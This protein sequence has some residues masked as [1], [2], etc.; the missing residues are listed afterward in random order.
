MSSIMRVNI[1]PPRSLLPAP[2]LACVKSYFLPA[3]SH[4]DQKAQPKR[5]TDGRK[6]TL[7]DDILQG[8]FHRCG[9]VLGGAHHGARSIGKVIDDRID[10]GAGI[11]VTA[12]RLLARRARERVERVS[13]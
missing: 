5:K 9:R 10:I 3:P 7:G 2:I 1:C 4:A 6:R 13:D 8:F 12:A 11:L